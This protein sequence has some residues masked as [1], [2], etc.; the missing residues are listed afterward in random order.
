MRL[1]TIS[2][3]LKTKGPKGVID[4]LK[5]T[6]SLLKRIV[7]AVETQKEDV[8]ASLPLNKN[9]RQSFKHPSRYSLS[10]GVHRLGVYELQISLWLTASSV[11]REL[12]QADIALNAVEEAEKVLLLFSQTQHYVRHHDSRLFKDE[13]ASAPP[14][15]GY[16]KDS[17]P[18]LARYQADIAL[19]V[20]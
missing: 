4:T 9:S 11:Y 1:T 2:L 10:S 5:T 6:F 19:E 14:S 15:G 20:L 17:D 13:G 18:V 7:G 8:L 3:E 12:G 16:W